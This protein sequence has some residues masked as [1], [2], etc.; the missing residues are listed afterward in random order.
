[1]DKE[2][3]YFYRNALARNLCSEYSSEF[4]HDIEDKQKLLSLSLRQQSIP[5]FCTAVYQ[6]W[7]LDVEYLKDAF[8]KYINGKYT[9]R[10]CDNVSGYT[11]QLWCAN[12][13][14][15]KIS[16]D[17]IHLLSCSC[18]VKTIKTKCPT[19]Y[20]SNGSN[21][22]LSDDGYNSI[23]VYLFDDSTLNI[24]SLDSTSRI[25]IYK[26][27]KECSVFV[28]DKCKGVV[29]QFDKDLIL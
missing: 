7:G 11:Y 29:K 6:K 22:E 27:S 2:M 24:K 17:V 21:I 15:V 3:F 23:R 14:R 13:K 10:N 18:K 9:A 25:L 19:I 8:K 20:I 26:Y 16:V 12:S 5:Y 28:A 1:M 4:K